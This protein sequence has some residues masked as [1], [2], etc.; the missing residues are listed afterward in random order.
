MFTRVGARAIPKISHH[1]ITS[2][3][4]LELDPWRINIGQ[5]HAGDNVADALAATKFEVGQ[6]MM[7]PKTSTMKSVDPVLLYTES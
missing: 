6:A 2:I 5:R 1:P 4:L 3:G 7:Y